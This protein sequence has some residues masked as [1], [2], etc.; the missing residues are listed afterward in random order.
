MKRAPVRKNLFGGYV[1][2]KKLTVFFSIFIVFFCSACAR[3]ADIDP[4]GEERKDEPAASLVLPGRVIEEEHKEDDSA[5]R[6]GTDNIRERGLYDPSIFVIEASGSWRQELAPGY[7]SDYE[8]ELYLDKFDSN[9]NRSASGLYTGI[10]WMKATVDAEGYLQELLKDV[11]A[12]IEFT[13]GGEGICDNLTMHLLDGYERDPF[14]DYTIPDGRGGSMEPEKE[15]LAGE[16][17]FIAV[18]K[19]AYLNANA[20]GAAGEVL[21]YQDNQTGDMEI[22]YVIQ[23][24]PDPAHTA[25]TRKATIYLSGAGGMNTTIEG[26]WRRLPGYRDDML[27]YANTGKSAEMLERHLQ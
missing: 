24:E 8:C 9:D 26:V 21:S 12:Q 1:M 11:P 25:S 13:A 17:G 6:S 16:G 5:D 10:F 27:E 18:G 19:Q 15:V 2:K 4:V 23:I 3:P 7:F 20:L 14:G 22:R